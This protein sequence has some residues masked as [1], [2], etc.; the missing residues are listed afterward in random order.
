MLEFISNIKYKS[1]NLS[2]KINLNLTKQCQLINVNLSMSTYQSQFINVN[3]SMSINQK[4][5]SKRA[6][7]R[8]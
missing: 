7:E 3:L 4:I 8:F 2:E 5:K 6:N 1:L